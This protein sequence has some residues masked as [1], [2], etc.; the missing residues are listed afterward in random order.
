[1]PAAALPCVVVGAA[2]LCE[3]VPNGRSINYNCTAC[4]PTLGKKLIK[5][6]QHDENL[7]SIILP[8]VKLFGKAKKPIKDWEKPLTLWKKQDTWISCHADGWKKHRAARWMKGLKGL[9]LQLGW[10]S[11]G[12]GLDV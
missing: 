6:E 9:F 5:R 1:V 12:W 8:S 2:T 10:W 3:Q 4:Q 7:F 11:S